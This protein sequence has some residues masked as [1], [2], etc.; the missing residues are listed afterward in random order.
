MGIE[1]CI[2][3]V[4]Y[5]S[6]KFDDVN[7]VQTIYRF[8][9]SNF[10]RLQQLDTLSSFIT[11]SRPLKLIQCAMA[12]KK[13]L[14]SSFFLSF[15]FS[16]I[17]SFFC[18]V[19]WYRFEQVSDHCTKTSD[20]WPKYSLKFYF[21]LVYAKYEKAIYTRYK[22]RMMKTNYL[23][24]TAQ[25]QLFFRIEQTTFQSWGCKHPCLWFAYNSCTFM[26]I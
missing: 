17:F 14:S 22:K 26:C 4:Q 9:A 18:A 10:V 8:M 12:T 23:K 7:F 16:S 1:F 24:C 19:A 20:K 11:N 6:I 3:A 21:S 2:V 15:D 5:E 13:N 25:N